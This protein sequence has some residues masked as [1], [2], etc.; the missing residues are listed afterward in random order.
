MKKLLA[1]LLAAVMLLTLCACGK[2]EETPSDET[3]PTYGT[4][5]PE[6][7]ASVAER[8]ITAYC[9][10]DKGTYFDLHCYDARQKWK[11]EELKNSKQTEA[12]YC[13]AAQKQAEERGL[14]IGF[15]IHNLDDYL[16]AKHEVDKIY[17]LEAYGTYTVTATAVD[18]VKLSETEVAERRGI[19]LNAGGDYADEAAI[20]TIT[21]IH[22]VT[23]NF[24]IDGEKKDLNE[25]YLVYIANYQGQWRVAGHTT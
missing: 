20:N 25:N 1:L 6:D 4:P 22:K 23:V 3:A 13:A 19:V 2:K 14:D 10:Q 5:P 12:E 7:I 24:V 17:K 11:D 21:E 8:F 18:S 16:T 15:A 9:T